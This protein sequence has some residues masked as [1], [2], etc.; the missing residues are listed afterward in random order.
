MPLQQLLYDQSERTKVRFVGLTTGQARYDFAIVYTKQFFEKPLVVCMQTGRS[1]LLCSE[2]AR[3][4]S[5]LQ[6]VFQLEKKEEA[7]ELSDFF[8]QN[9]PRVPS[10]SR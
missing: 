8:I 5:Y 10:E 4:A 3:N 9:L 2:E 1:T 7:D 6:Q